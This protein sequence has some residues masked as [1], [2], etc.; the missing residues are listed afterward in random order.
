MTARRIVSISLPHLA[1]ERW[2]K[3]RERIGTP[4]P[5]DVPVVLATEGHHG[6]VIHA[7][8]RA[9]TLKGIQPGE[10][11]V[12][13]RA[14]CPDLKVEYA[15][16][17]GDRAVLE[18][19]VIWSRR[20]SPFTAPDGAAGIVLDTTG[21]AHLFGG[22]AALLYDIEE[23]FARIGLTTRSA[24]APTWGAAWALA[25]FGPVRAICGEEGLGRA[26]APLPTRALRLDAGTVQ[27]LHRLGLK[28]VADIA[29]IPR[30][31]LTRRFAKAALTGNPL[32]RL[33]QA[34]GLMGEPVSSK[35]AP[36]PIRAIARL[37]EPIQDPTP[38]LLDLCA[39][40][41]AQ[42][43]HAGMGCRRVEVVVYR[44]DGEV[45]TV[46]AAISQPS[47]DPA[48]LA[49]LFEGKLER[50]NPGFGFDLITLHAGGVEPLSTRQSR[51]D[52]AAQDGLPLAHLIDRLSARFGA[53]AILRP[54]ARESHVPERAEQ[55]VPALEAATDAA[56]LP[57]RER[58]I[59]L[60][61]SPEEIRVIYAV[62]EGPPAQFVWRRQRLHVARYAG[63]ERIAP[64]W[65]QDLPGTRL[66]DYYKIED[67]QGRRFWLYREGVHGDGRGGDPRWFM[68]GMFA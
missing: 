7:A 36:P 12:D 58:P 56:T 53:D 25:R 20:W 49:R 59:R 37:P 34:M 67:Q 11:V 48:H 31:S 44:T 40:L 28:T 55:M 68:H 50:L 2:Q 61:R 3:H 17:A 15:D 54:I 51:L 32:M 16:I 35:E 27:L 19:L 22:E 52:G 66:R 26:L 10:R 65:W 57:A 43:D 24:M 39:D 14:L 13:M 46:H 42:L 62:P 1:M 38:H 6:P 30:L 63:P 64:E 9:A 33:D 5:P 47:R 45:S 60:L 8:N 4:P 18:R 23:Q 21:V 29:A 41:C